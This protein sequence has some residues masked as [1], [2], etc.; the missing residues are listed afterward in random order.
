VVIETTTDFKV[1]TPVYSATLTSGGFDWIAPID[2]TESARFFR[3]APP[4]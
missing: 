3:V 4:R 2:P 1:W